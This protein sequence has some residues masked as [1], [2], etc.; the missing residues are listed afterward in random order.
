[1]N[2]LLWHLLPSLLLT[3]TIIGV[4]AI[5]YDTIQGQSCFQSMQGMLYSMHDLADNNSN[6]M[7][8]TNIGKSYLK[9]NEGHKLG[10]YDISTGGYD[11]YVTKVPYTNKH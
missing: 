2:I 11:I 8:I 6:L 7:T 10:K 5:A 9:H 1:M 4:D 3:I